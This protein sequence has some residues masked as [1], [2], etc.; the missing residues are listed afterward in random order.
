MRL[1]VMFALFFL[2]LSLNCTAISPVQIGGNHTQDVLSMVSYD[3]FLANT[4]GRSG[5]WGWGS[6]PIG[7]GQ[8]FP[9]GGSY[10]FGGWAP[11]GETPFNY[12]LNETPPEYTTSELKRVFSRE[13]QSEVTQ[14]WLTGGV[15]PVSYLPA[16]SPRMSSSMGFFSGYGDWGPAI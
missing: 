10:S 14:Y 1:L 16:E 12:T 3:P 9:G 4:Q 15:E 2:A 5:L 13:G 7:Y 8:L 11:F 6:G